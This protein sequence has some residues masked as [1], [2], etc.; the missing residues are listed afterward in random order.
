MDAAEALSDLTQISP[1]IDRAVVLR[2]DGSVE[3]STLGDEQS[4]QRMSDG[5]LALFTAADEAGAALGRRPV[6][7]AEIATPGGS[8]FVVRDA[9]RAVCAVTGCDP[10]VGLIFYDLKTC[11]RQ[12]AE[13]PTDVVGDD[14]GEGPDGEG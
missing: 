7:Q 10:T 5:A 6:V 2:A 12:I 1:Q 14:A 11:L 4:A 3:A 13:R 9:E 8:V